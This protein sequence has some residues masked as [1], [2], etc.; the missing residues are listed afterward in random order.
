MRH[1]MTH[2]RTNAATRAYEL[3]IDVHGLSMCRG[4]SWVVSS[5]AAS[6]LL[7]PGI[8]CG[9]AQ[10]SA[11]RFVRGENGGGFGLRPKNP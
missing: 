11:W 4:T 8:L 9:V 10:Y 7:S 6:G 1:R 5:R 3:G 2:R